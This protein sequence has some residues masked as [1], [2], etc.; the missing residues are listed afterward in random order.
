MYIYPQ[1]YDGKYVK[2]QRAQKFVKKFLREDAFQDAFPGNY[3][4]RPYDHRLSRLLD[5]LDRQWRLAND[6]RDELETAL[7][8]LGNVIEE[9]RRYNGEDY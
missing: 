1:K 3:N 2:K 9:I 8:D 4:H 7:N 5:D 6:A